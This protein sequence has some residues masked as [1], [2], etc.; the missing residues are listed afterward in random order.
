M[1][2]NEASIASF[3]ARQQQA[4]HLERERWKRDGQLNF[5]VEAN[6]S[7]PIESS[8]LPAGVQAVPSPVP[9]SVWRVSIKEGDEVNR[10]QSL[11]VLESM[12]ME[13]A[14][15]APIT[16]VVRNLLCSEGQPVTAGQALVT[17][18]ERG[19]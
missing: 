12:K 19:A 15:E 6:R 10:G 4:F 9:G 16:G 5:T 8:E 14:L 7:A 17:I 1:N 11:L 18:Q 2:D 3:K 13:V